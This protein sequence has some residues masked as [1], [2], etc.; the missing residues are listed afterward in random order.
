MKVSILVAARNEEVT[1]KSCLESLISQNV[2]NNV[3]IDILIGND[4][5]KDNT[6]Q[7]VTGFVAEFDN[8]KL[9]NIPQDRTLKGK[10]NVLDFLSEQTDAEYFLF[11]DADVVYPSSWVKTMLNSL[12]SADI[13]TGVTVVEQ[14][15]L[16]SNYQRMDWMFALKMIQVLSKFGIPVTAMGNNLGIRRSMFEKVGG[17]R[18][19]PFSVAED[20]ALFKEVIR[21]GGRFEQLFSKDVL[22]VTQPVSTLPQWL[23]QRWRWMQGAN[24]I[25]LPL[26]VLNYLN[27]IFYPLL[28]LFGVFFN[29]LLWLIPVVYVVKSATIITIQHQ[30]GLKIQWRDS[31]MFDLF[32]AFTYNILLIYSLKKP[33]VHWKGRV[34]KSE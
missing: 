13:V 1:I 7:I 32:H 20:F 25:Q 6:E 21:V 2:N 15:N 14:G 18:D 28:I 8:I 22:A 12:L 34:Y 10:V 30:L 29:E 31:L 17:V 24:K 11:A 3:C 26:K 27:I 19:I 9:F 23:R 33:K 16:W 5:S 4:A